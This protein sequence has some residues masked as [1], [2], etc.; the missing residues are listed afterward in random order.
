MRFSNASSS[1][2]TVDPTGNDRGRGG[3][4][5]PLTE[6][7]TLV[8]LVTCVT[9]V[10]VLSARADRTAARF[11]GGLLPVVPSGI[12]GGGEV[13]VE[14]EVDSAGRVAS[15]STVRTTPPF[16]DL[17]ADAVR[18]W[19]FDPAEEP[20]IDPER[21]NAPP[22]RVAVASNVLVA[23]IF[24]PPTILGPSLGEAPR[25]VAA[26]SPDVA[27]PMSMAMPSFPPTALNPGLVLLEAMI[28]ASGAVADAAI[29]RSAPPFDAAA[30]A[31]LRQWRFRPA[32]WRG[33][34][35][36]T[37]VYVIVGFAVPIG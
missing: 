12:V 20:R 10:A 31:T 25:D 16:G 27:A 14:L 36:P 11:R 37:Y 33:A 30:L 1:A 19:Q 5:V 22:Q 32:R 2:A 24:R 13:V 7:R 34:P 35:A 28:D 23:A 18:S 21:P 17:V 6:R 3:E 4:R 8:V 29:L 26:A 15:A 9:A